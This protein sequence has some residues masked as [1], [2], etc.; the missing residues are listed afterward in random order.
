MSRKGPRWFVAKVASSPS[1]VSAR[2]LST[3]ARV[4]DEHVQPRGGLEDLRR[5]APHRRE[6]GQIEDDE[7]ELPLTAETLRQRRDGSATLVGV[8]GRHQDPG[9]HRGQRRRGLEADAGIATR[10]DDRLP[11]HVGHRVQPPRDGQASAF[12]TR[13]APALTARC[14]APRP[15]PAPGARKLPLNVRSAVRICHCSSSCVASHAA[16]LT[17]SPPSASRLCVCPG[18]DS[19]S[20]S[21]GGR[22]CDAAREL[23]VLVAR[24]PRDRQSAVAHRDAEHRSRPAGWP[25]PRSSIRSAPCRASAREPARPARR[26]RAT[27]RRPAAAPPTPRNSQMVGSTSTDSVTARCTEPRPRSASGRGSTTMSGT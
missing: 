24:S 11:L 22:T 19:R 4:V 21:S 1:T 9:P 3:G 2:S 7:L 17:A 20:N 13:D 25:G 14:R 5:P 12:H 15:V 26:G 6:V 10:D 27:S 18:S 16:A 8:A 23:H